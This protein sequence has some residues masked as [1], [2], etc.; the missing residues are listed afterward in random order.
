MPDYNI[1][2]CWIR[3]AVFHPVE[4]SIYQET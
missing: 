3:T 1:R 2:N 4:E